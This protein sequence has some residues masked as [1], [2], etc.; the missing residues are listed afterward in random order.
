VYAGFAWSKNLSYIHVGRMQEMQDQFSVPVR[1]VAES[2]RQGRWSC[3]LCRMQSSALLQIKRNLPGFY[4]G[5]VLSRH[6]INPSMGA[7]QK[8]PV[9]EGLENTLPP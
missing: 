7:L 3:R 9:F 8:H 4:S 2:G 1:S 6:A 5:S